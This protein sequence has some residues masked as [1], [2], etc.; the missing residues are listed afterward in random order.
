LEVTQ[1]IA[2]IEVFTFGS[3][4]ILRVI[5]IEEYENQNI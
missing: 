3:D 2:C 4:K 1:H 5:L